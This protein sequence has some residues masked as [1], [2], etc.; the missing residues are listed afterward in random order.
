MIRL[1]NL[2]YFD[3]LQRADALRQ[4]RSLCDAL[5]SVDK[6]TFYAHR[7]VLA[8]ASRTLAR[9][10]SLNQDSP[11]QFTL[12]HFSSHTFQQLLDFIYSQTLEVSQED[13]KLLLRAAQMLEMEELEQQCMRLLDRLQQEDK[14]S[15]EH[16]KLEK[17]GNIKKL[18]VSPAVEQCHRDSVIT[19]SSSPF[20]PWTLPAHMW[21]SRPAQASVLSYSHLHS[22]YSPN[23]GSLKTGGIFR[24]GLLKKK[25]HR[26]LA[27]TTQ[28]CKTSYMDVVKADTLRDCQH[29]SAQSQGLQFVETVAEK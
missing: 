2:Q 15:I 25:K 16:I 23:P 11:V 13:L 26:L 4:S 17:E 8:C 14:K 5:I 3:F 29:C 21:G 20:S 10:L 12:E 27:Q 24:Q 9:L 1:N 6:H 18:S 7:V 22:H 19:S 28:S